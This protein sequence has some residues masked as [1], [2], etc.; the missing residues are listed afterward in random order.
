LLFVKAPSVALDYAPI[1]KNKRAAAA[2]RGSASG[3]MQYDENRLAQ[4]AATVAAGFV[5]NS[6]LTVAL[7]DK[8]RARAEARSLA[9]VSLMIARHIMVGAHCAAQQVDALEILYEDADF[10]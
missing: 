1:S 9:R 6:D 7:A 3:H 8:H 5:R 2:Y 4:L 10:L